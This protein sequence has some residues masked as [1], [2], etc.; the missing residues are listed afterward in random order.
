MK[1][2]ILNSF[3]VG[4]LSLALGACSTI[5]EYEEAV[6]VTRFTGNMHDRPYAQGLYQ[7]FTKGLHTYDLR[8]T[9]HPKN[10]KADAVPVLTSDQL[11]VTLEVAYLW[12]I[13]PGS[14][15]QLFL[16]VG[17]Q[18][19]V[20]HLVY[21]SFRSVVRDLGAEVNAES[22]LSEGRKGLADR[23]LSAMNTRLES[24]GVL[25]TEF[26]IRDVEPPKSLK[27][28]IEGKLRRQQEEQTEK[29]QTAIIR[30]KAEQRREEAQ[31]I[32]DA[33]RIISESLTGESGKRY[34]YWRALEAMEHIGEG[35]NNMV[36]VPTDGG[37]PIFF[38]APKGQ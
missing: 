25:I 32:K 35:E 5:S 27:A 38:G 18:E 6:G 3:L 11:T 14:S 23:I 34:L 36:V 29:Y 1:S 30:E 17:D 9:Q 7:V 26:F 15:T 37:V 12:K 2:K 22:L 21:K 20:A 13:L 33:Q 24:R 8:E 31:G 19:A 4:L 28:A 10:E 16:D